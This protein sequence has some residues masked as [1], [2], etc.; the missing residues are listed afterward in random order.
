MQPLPLSVIIVN[1]NAGPL[2]GEC[3]R[4]VQGQAVREVIV[5]DNAS[6]DGSLA[7]LRE[8]ADPAALVILETGRNLGFA[9]ACNIGLRAATQPFLLFLNPDSVP[10]SGS[11]ARLLQV[12]EQHPAAGMVGGLLLNPDGTEQRGGRR[13]IPTPGQVLM[14]R[15]FN[16]HGTPLPTQPTVVEAIS[17]A[18]MLVRRQA[19]AAVGP[20]DEGYFLHCED[21]DWCLRFRQKGWDIL[22]V[23]DA[24]VV[25]YQGTSSRAR[26]LFVEWHKH[27]GMLRF[28]RKFFRQRTPG[29]LMGLVALGVWLRF[30]FVALRHALRRMSHRGPHG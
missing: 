14:R 7:L 12:L 1:H 29:P 11:L 9:A 22:F 24:P 18:L 3:V 23:P 2:L 17:G 15:P 10:A 20:W 21:L 27:R 16:L 5:V 26:P 13:D 25:H 4:A 6:T 19:V 8:R 28:Y 30:G